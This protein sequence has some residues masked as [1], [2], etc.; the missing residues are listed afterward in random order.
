MSLIRSSELFVEHAF[1]IA[2]ERVAQR[3]L[4]KRELH[5]HE[6]FE[7]LFVEQGT[8]VNCFRNEEISLY[9]GDM[10]IMKPYVLHTLSDTT[11][12]DRTAYCCSFLP[13]AVDSG[14]QSLESLQ[15]SLSPNR[16]F[17]QS[18]FPLG[19]D[20]VG[21]IRIKVDG[22]RKDQVDTLFR[23]LRDETHDASERAKARVRLLFLE[24]LLLLAHESRKD[25]LHTETVHL[26]MGGS[27]SRYQA[28]L[29]KTLN[30]IH[31]HFSEALR[32]SDLV[33]MSGASETYFSRLFKH[34]TGMTYQNYVNCL[35]IE[36][37]CALLRETGDSALDI[38]YA[39]GF[40]DYTHFRRRFKKYAGMTPIQFRKQ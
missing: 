5:R 14:I 24:L 32:Y 18:L 29:R 3:S 27:A 11:G 2:V 30:Y 38:C 21:A 25:D 20:A 4:L 37:A 19:E 13:Q 16:Y 33:A 17:F 40:N 12:Q 10:L 35:R 23:Q 6:Y 39:V 1:P 26:Q 36:E 15:T 34:E 9:P 8:L 7:M 22:E 28:G 31:D